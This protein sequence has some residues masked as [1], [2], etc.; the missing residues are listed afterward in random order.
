MLIKEMGEE[1]E[2][3]TGQGDSCN[4]LPTFLCLTSPLVVHIVTISGLGVSTTFLLLK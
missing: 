1:T 4:P 3:A 2:A